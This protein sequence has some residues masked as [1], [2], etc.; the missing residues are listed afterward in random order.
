MSE[1][2]NG[3]LLSLTAEAVEIY[4]T[5]VQSGGEI[6]EELEKRLSEVQNTLTKKVDAYDWILKSLEADEEK[7]RARAEMFLKVAKGLKAYR[8]RLK[9]NIKF[10][11]TQL[12]TTELNGLDVR[13]TLTKGQPALKIDEQALPGEFKVVTFSPDK[14]KIKQALENG[15][16]VPGASL[17]PS[18]QLR[19]YAVKK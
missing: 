2:N 10:A 11:M 4:Q 5:L 17:E 6:T 9:D 15:L 16:E 8:E 12:E 14:T 3:N 13:F 18:V 19:V 7:F 1:N